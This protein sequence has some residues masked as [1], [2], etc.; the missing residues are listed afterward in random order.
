MIHRH[1]ENPESDTRG[2]HL[3][4]QIPAISWLTHPEP[5][6]RVASDSAKWAHV[7]VA[8]AVKKSQDQAGDSARKDLLEIHAA[9]FALAS[10]ARPNHEVVFFS[11]DWIDKLIHEFGAI[12]PVAIEKNYD[13]GLRRKRADSGHARAAV[14]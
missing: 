4:L 7:A 9:G 8:N 14:T 12:A 10:R 6:E 11:D 3:H 1:F 13:V 2:P 5:I